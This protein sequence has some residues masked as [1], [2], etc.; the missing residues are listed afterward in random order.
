M[1]VAGFYNRSHAIG[2]GELTSGQ[3]DEAL[4]G[5][6]FVDCSIGQQQ[7]ITQSVISNAGFCDMNFLMSVLISPNPSF[8]PAE[9]L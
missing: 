8:T 1:A 7:A 2:D 5:P 3:Q 4:F 6:A 9:P